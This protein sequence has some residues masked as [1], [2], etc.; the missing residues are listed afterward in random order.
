MDLC[1]LSSQFIPD[2]SSEEKLTKEDLLTPDRLQNLNPADLEKI[3]KDFMKNY[4]QKTENII[5]DFR[6]NIQQVT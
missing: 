3:G 5:K 2:E 1:N 6:S 4:K